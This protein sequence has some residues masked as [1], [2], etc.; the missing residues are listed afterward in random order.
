MFSKFSK[1]VLKNSFQK[2]ALNFSL[3]LTKGLIQE[4]KKVTDTIQASSTNPNY[5]CKREIKKKDMKVAPRTSSEESK[6][7]GSET[8]NRIQHEEMP[9]AA[10]VP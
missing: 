6:V 5:I 10:V 3:P 7:E 4:K 8:A 2:H 1:T 9:M